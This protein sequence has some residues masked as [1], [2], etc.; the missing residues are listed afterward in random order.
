MA[1]IAL[2]RL[3]YLAFG[4]LER[5]WCNI[6][7]TVFFLCKTEVF[8]TLKS[9]QQKIEGSFSFNHRQTKKCQFNCTQTEE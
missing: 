5:N 1:K 7:I 4:T 2:K 6:F 9:N 3:M 8:L